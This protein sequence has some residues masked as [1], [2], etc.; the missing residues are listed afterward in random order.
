M[1]NKQTINPFL[2]LENILELYK[3]N[4]DKYICV[5]LCENKIQ[6]IKSFNQQNCIIGD[7]L[8]LCSNNKCTSV[9]MID[10]VV[11]IEYEKK[12][13]VKLAIK[14]GNALDHINVSIV[15]YI[16]SDYRERQYYSLRY[17]DLMA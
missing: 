9:L 7:I 13:S 16:L 6:C 2:L 15:D 5:T 10:K 12:S 17:H 14:L 3:N 11:K 1:N 4:Y 8:K